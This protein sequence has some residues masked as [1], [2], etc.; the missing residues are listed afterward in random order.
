MYAMYMRMA[1]LMLEKAFVRFDVRSLNFL[2][3]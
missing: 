3:I 2:E 1:Q